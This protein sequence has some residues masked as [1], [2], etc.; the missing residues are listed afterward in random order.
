[1][2]G[3]GPAT[4]LSPEGGIDYNTPTYTWE[5]VPNATYYQLAVNEDAGGNVFLQWYASE[6]I[7]NEGFCSVTPATAQANGN[8]KWYVQTYNINGL[9][10][11]ST[12]L[13]CTVEGAQPGAAT[14]VSPRGSN[15][16]NTPIYTWEEVP[17]AE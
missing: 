4:L 17:N 7:C 16:D 15:N 6:E 9:G 11:W 12:G 3:I 2:A 14:L 1:M 8:Y 10:P 5:E 13:S